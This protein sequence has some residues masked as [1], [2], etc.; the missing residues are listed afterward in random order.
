MKMWLFIVCVCFMEAETEVFAF[1]RRTPLTEM[2]WEHAREGRE[3][4][5]ES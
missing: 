1:T 4:A 3:G 5:K 2:P